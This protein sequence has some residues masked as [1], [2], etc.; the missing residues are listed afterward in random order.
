MP[1]HPQ[2][3]AEELGR[4]PTS[5]LPRAERPAFAPKRPFSFSQARGP[6]TSRSP[7]PARGSMTRAGPPSPLQ[8]AHRAPPS[9]PGPWLPLQRKLGQGYERED[10]EARARARPGLDRDGRNRSRSRSRSRSPRHSGAE[11]LAS[12]SASEAE[13]MTELIVISDD[14]DDERCNPGRSSSAGRTCGSWQSRI[15]SGPQIRRGRRIRIKH[16]IREAE[17]SSSHAVVDFIDLTE[18]PDPVVKTYPVGKTPDGVSFIDLTGLEDEEEEEEEE[19]EGPFSS[20]YAC[21]NSVNLDPESGPCSQKQHSHCA[22]DA[23]HPIKSEVTRRTPRPEKEARGSLPSGQ[24][25]V[26]GSECEERLPAVSSGED[27]VCSSER[28]CSTTTFNSDLGSLASS[29]LSSDVFSLSP[30]S[31][32][33]DSGSQRP[34]LLKDS[35]DRC[36]SNWQKKGAS[37][38]RAGQL[39]KDFSPVAQRAPWASALESPDR[40]AKPAAARTGKA[41]ENLPRKPCLHRLRYFLRPPVHHLFFQALIQDKEVPENKEQKK[42]PIPHR[43]LRMVFSTIEEN[44]P[45]ETLQFLMDFVSPQHYPPKDIVS[46]VIKNILLGSESMADRKEAYM[47]LMKIQQLHPANVASVEWD[48]KLVTSVMEK[49]EEELPGRILFLRYVVQTLEDD[50]QQVLRRQRHHLQQSIA[51]NVL[52]CDKQPQNIRDIIQWLVGAV[53]RL[54]FDQKEDNQQTFSGSSQD[55]SGDHLLQPFPGRSNHHLVILHLQR[56][57]SLAVEVDRTPTCSSNKIAEMMFGFVLNIPERSQREIFFTTMESHLLRCKVLEVLF[58]HSCEKPT[59]LPLSLAQTL[60]FLNHSTSLLKNQS[61]KSNWQSWDELVEHLQFL[62]SSYQHVLTEHLRTSVIERKDLLIK[63]IKP[64]LQEGDDITSLDVEIEF[65]A[66]GVRLARELGEPL[67]PQLQ[68]K[69]FLL[70]LLL[71]CATNRNFML[72]NQVP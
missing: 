63:R 3:P 42:E 53:T 27:S 16:W 56:M 28:N 49:Q 70:K 52:S 24:D 47:L 13:T 14:S 1:F 68:E 62:L 48:W 10:A 30:N 22:A 43:R 15:R 19:G 41:P 55:K 20:A 72:E 57:L 39:L 8:S 40:A 67:V 66:F 44:V 2:S 34:S 37:A 4:P 61:E 35:P 46:H 31:S 9:P 65:K 18:D 60:Y 69:I 51:C 5:R 36:A 38:E 54:G 29:R 71:L 6:G 64:H 11:T 17:S 32:C 23:G 59:P 12:R 21:K 58:L 33:S 7:S 45:R 26:W 25:P 50:F